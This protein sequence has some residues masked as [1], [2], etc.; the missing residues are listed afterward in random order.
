MAFNQLKIS[1]YFDNFCPLCLNVKHKIEIL[2]WF[3]L[4][5][6]I[7]IRDSDIKEKTYVSVAI[8][9][10]SMHA[11]IHRNNKIVNGIDAFVSLSCRL[12]LL[13]PLWPLLKLSSFIGIGGLIYQ[14]VAD[15]RNIV[16]VGKCDD[17]CKLK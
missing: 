11:K 6:M 13:L 14:Y 10:K 4:V 17:S 12:P 2:D 3:N 9:E 8:L 1:V 16:P 7:G 5:D 15:N